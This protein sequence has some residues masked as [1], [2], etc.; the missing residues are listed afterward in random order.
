MEGCGYVC[1]NCEEMEI[2]IKI[3]PRKKMILLAY[4]KA[5]EKDD[6]TLAVQYQPQLEKEKL[7]V[8]MIPDEIV[9]TIQKELKE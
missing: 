7:C 3:K 6:I 4:M 2:W 5:L 9:Q 8:T 1:S